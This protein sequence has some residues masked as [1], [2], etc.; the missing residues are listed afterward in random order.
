[1]RKAPLVGFVLLLA[2]LAAGCRDGAGGGQVGVVRNGGPYDNKAIKDCLP[3][4]ARRKYIGLNSTAHKYPAVGV[5]RYFKITSD[6]KEG[7]DFQ[8][9][10]RAKTA[11]GFNVHLAGTFFF[12][13]NFGCEQDKRSFDLT[14]GQ[15]VSY[16]PRELVED[17]DKQFGVRKFPDPEGG[18]DKAPWEEGDRGWGAFLN[19]TMLPIIQNELRVAMLKFTCE[20]VV[21]SCALVASRNVADA[22]KKT[23]V[24][25]EEAKQTGVNLQKV[26]TEIEQGFSQ[27][28][29]QTFGK[30]YFSKMKFLMSQ[31]DLDPEIEIA[32]NQSLAS[33]AQVSQAQAQ[34]QQAA[35]TAAAGRNLSKLYKNNP[36]LAELEKWRIICGVKPGDNSTG[37][38]SNIQIITGLGSS[39]VILGK[40]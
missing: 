3:P 29:E 10:V 2:L 39:P 23:G 34:V 21:S 40:K 11:D 14:N 35:K 27:E 7:A 13:T 30:P 36:V 6:P 25:K 15:S 5:Q 26:Q 19:A 18:G 28:I 9:V 31:P 20:E 32:I 12:E 4:A 8:G 22:K 17:F 24:T 1:M 38:C 16:S 33:F 37:H